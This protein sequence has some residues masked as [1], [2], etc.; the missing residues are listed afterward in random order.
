MI[1]KPDY[2][3]GC[4]WLGDGAGYVPDEVPAGCD[5]LFV[6]Q[7]PGASEE[8]QAR[9]MIGT[10]GQIWRHQFVARHLSGARVGHANLI[11]C[12]KQDA[13]GRRSNALPPVRSKE[14]CEIVAHCRPA[15]EATFRAAGDVDVVVP[16]GEHAVAAM[17]DLIQR[18]R[19]KPP[20][21]HLRGTFMERE[22]G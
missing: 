4:P 16:V 20:M 15:L 8:Q 7:N 10:T 11:K 3:K 1:P 18:G 14:W 6:Y 5:V 19:K 12:R 13:A 21:L 17:T 2:C 22:Q 9:P